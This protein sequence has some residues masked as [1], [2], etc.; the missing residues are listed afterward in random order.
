MKVGWWGWSDK[1][2]GSVCDNKFYYVMHGSNTRQ[3]QRQ[4]NTQREIEREKKFR[5]YTVIRGWREWFGYYSERAESSEC[6][7]ERR[8][9]KSK[10]RENNQLAKKKKSNPPKQSIVLDYNTSTTRATLIFLIRERQREGER[11]LTLFVYV[12]LTTYSSYR[13]NL[14]LTPADQNPVFWPPSMRRLR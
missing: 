1:G 3:E 4:Q 7:W 2:G 8:E 10:Q 12:F 14:C 9:R 13:A 11:F 6:E 5:N